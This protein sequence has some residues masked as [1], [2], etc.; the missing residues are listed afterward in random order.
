MDRLLI[1]IMAIVI[2][3]AGGYFVF[4]YLNED[5]DITV[6]VETFEPRMI[7]RLETTEILASN[8]A[9]AVRENQVL[10]R[11]NN[12]VMIMQ[13]SSAAHLGVDFTGFDWGVL[14]GVGEPLPESGSIVISG[15]L[16]PLEILN[17]FVISG[18]EATEVMS[19]NRNYD[20]E[21][22]LGPL[23]VAQRGQLMACVAERALYR[24][25]AIDDAKEMVLALL[26]AAIP[27]RPDGSSPVR[28]DLSFANESELLA[29][30]AAL[31]GQPAPCETRIYAPN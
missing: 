1:A 31:G 17:S 11:E 29:E 12:A 8:T 9:I 7:Q 15:D 13:W 14:S 24:Q 18:S 10:G 22:E 3:G 28:F 20:E 19:R 16:P 27:L 2:G 26:S 30:I 25:A 23:L 6:Q 5:I 4:D 21:A